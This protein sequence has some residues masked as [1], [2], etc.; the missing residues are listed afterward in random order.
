MRLYR[1]TCNAPGHSEEIISKYPR[2]AARTIYDQK[3]WWSDAWD[4]LAIGR[5]YDFSKPF[6]EQL[7]TFCREAPIPA[8]DVA[9]STNCDYCVTAQD[10]KNCYFVIGGFRAEECLY[11]DTPAFGRH[12]VDSYAC[13]SGDTLYEC[14]YCDGSYNLKYSEF[15]EGC[16]DSA[17]LYD[18]KGCSDCFGCVNLRNKKYCIWNVQ[19]SKEE[20]RERMKAIDLSSREKVAELRQ[21]YVELL[22]RYPVRYANIVSS[23][24]CT[25]DVID[26]GR[27]CRN[28]SVRQN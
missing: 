22:G 19:Y 7:D 23:T 18:C 5:E 20:Y 8:L 4:P 2:S 26:G 10:S 28:C 14:L 24:D 13:L 27:N 15:S 21:R 6:F 25:G 1:R 3:F 9:N 11:S 12:V 16:M 17:F